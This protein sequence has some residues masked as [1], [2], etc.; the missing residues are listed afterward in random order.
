MSPNLVLA[1]GSPRRCQLLDGL[2]VAYEK[3]PVDLDESL[4]EG[5]APVDYVLRLAREKAAAR[6]TPG[7]VVLAADTTVVC[8]KEVLGK[9]VDDADAERMLGLLAGRSHDVLTGVAVYEPARGH[10]VSRS[11]RT[12]VSIAPMTA[13]EISWYVDTGE[14]LDKAGSYAIQGL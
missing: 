9:P 11:E 2:G 5:E 6:D 10:L 4:L 14:P 3:R 7:E 1:S 8:D 12:R 13:T